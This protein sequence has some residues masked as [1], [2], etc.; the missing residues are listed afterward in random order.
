MNNKPIGIF[1]SGLGGLTLVHEIKKILPNENIIYLGDTARVPYGTRSKSTIERFSLQDAK[2][3]M[4][5]R[6]KCIVIA[7]NTASALAYEYLKNRIRVP[8]ID[9]ISTLDDI[10]FDKL[11]KVGVIGTSATI[12]S[13]AH[14]KLIKSRNSKIKIYT[15]ACPLFVPLVESGE[16]KGRLVDLIVEK[17]LRELKIQKLDALILGCTHYPLIRKSISKYMEITLI[18]PAE[19]TSLRLKDFLKDMNLETNRK[20]KG[21]SKYFVT[22]KVADF[23]KIAEMFLGEKLTGLVQKVDLE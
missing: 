15:K 5:K 10:D 19:H 13:M 11:S 7:C 9:V 17:Y 2:F 1:D 8:M 3:L 20:K 23:E 16:T 22:D 6:V 21:K 14:E 18:N 4:D 12:G